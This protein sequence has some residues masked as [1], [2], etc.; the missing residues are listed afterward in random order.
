MN[1]G[2]APWQKGSQE[3][4]L[5]GMAGVGGSPDTSLSSKHCM[6]GPEI[7]MPRVSMGSFHGMEP[8]EGQPVGWQPGSYLEAVEEELHAIEAEKHLTVVGCL[9]CDVPQGTPGELHDLVTLRGGGCS[10]AVSS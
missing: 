8:V 3:A 5:G 10:S 7:L 1:T 9:V 6:C 2:W 4:Q